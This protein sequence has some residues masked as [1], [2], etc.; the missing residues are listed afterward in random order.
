MRVIQSL[1]FD[2]TLLDIRLAIYHLCRA[3]DVIY[4]KLFANL[5]S[6]FSVAPFL[7]PQ[8][9]LLSVS[10]DNHKD[11]LQKWIF[12]SDT[13]IHHVEK[14]NW[15]YVSFSVYSKVQCPKS[16]QCFWICQKPL[17]TLWAQKIFFCFGRFCLQKFVQQI[18]L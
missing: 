12:L 3:S 8:S 2:Q 13:F 7:W 18:A 11:F 15:G 6:V 16:K 10:H 9:M 4:K 14:Y 1:N 17:Q 5:I